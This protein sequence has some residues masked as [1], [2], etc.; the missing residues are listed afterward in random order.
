MN[1]SKIT[2]AIINSAAALLCCIAV[3]VG[4]STVANKVCDNKLAIADASVNEIITSPPYPM[5]EMWDGDISHAG[6]NREVSA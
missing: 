4:S 5:I 6:E 3:A 2:V 1:K